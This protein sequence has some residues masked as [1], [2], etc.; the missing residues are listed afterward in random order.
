MAEPVLKPMLRVMPRLRVLS[1]VLKEFLRA[2]GAEE[3]VMDIVDKGVYQKQLI[4]EFVLYYF[5][6]E[7]CLGKATL[8]IDWEKHEIS[9]NTDSG[10]SFSFNE[11]GSLIEQIDKASS[12]V[13][14]HVNRLRK[15][16]HIDRIET[17]FRYKE[18]IREDK[19]KLEETRKLLGLTKSDPISLSSSVEFKNAVVYI[20]DKLN[21]LTII[22]ES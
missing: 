3:T 19:D 5:S 17:H 8:H 14:Y 20:M 2:F 22:V 7:N 11:G 12:L 4:E 21:E 15:E 1:I 9:L 6:G 18:E 16:L 10:K 13:I